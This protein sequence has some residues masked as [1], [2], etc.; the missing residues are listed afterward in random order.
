MVSVLST[1]LCK[2]PNFVSRFPANE[3]FDRG[4]IAENVQWYLSEKWPWKSDAERERYLTKDFEGW[5]LMI[6]GDAPSDRTEAACLWF[7]WLFLWDDMV[8]KMSSSEARLSLV[9]LAEIFS[10]TRIPKDP[11]PIERIALAIRDMLLEVDDDDLRDLGRSILTQV[12][13]FFTAI[14]SK[15]DRAR[16]FAGGFDSFIK[17]RL[18]DVGG[19]LA[20]ELL[21]WARGCIIPPNAKSTGLADLVNISLLHATLINDFFSYEVEAEV[22]RELEFSGRKKH[23]YMVFNTVAVLMAEKSMSRTD[24]YVELIEKIKV[25]EKRYV[26]ALDDLRIRHRESGEDLTRIEEVSDV[27]VDLMGGNSVWSETCGRY[28]PA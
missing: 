4:V 26:K 15:Q 22:L 3:H 23:G 19:R 18:N 24:A 17:Y 11:T 12:C 20:L 28:N 25:V 13:H 16:A 21:L 2:R 10:D 7:S 27:L 14:G 1:A 5:G 6:L 9:Q 8:E